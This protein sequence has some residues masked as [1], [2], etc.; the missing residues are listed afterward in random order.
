[1]NHRDER[2]G[3]EITPIFNAAARGPTKPPETPE[4]ELHHKPPERAPDIALPQAGHAVPTKLS[5][6]ERV[7]QS[8]ALN[9]A[10]GP[11]RGPEP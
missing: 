6:K 4:L 8:R 10:R 9:Q 1:M 3:K 2:D 11:D 7:L 5:I